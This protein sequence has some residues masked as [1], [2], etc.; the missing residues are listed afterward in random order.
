MR[1]GLEEAKKQLIDKLGKAVTERATVL[2]FPVVVRLKVPL[3]D[4]DPLASGMRAVIHGHTHQPSDELQNGV[5]FL[6]PG[7]PT[8]P[9]RT[10]PPSL[11]KLYIMGTDLRPEF[12]HLG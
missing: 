6:N 1:Y 12:I 5:R 11:M 3:L 7:S 8:H 10:A 4:M 9:R 2:S